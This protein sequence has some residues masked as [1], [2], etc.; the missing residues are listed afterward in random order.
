M[1]VS[2]KTTSKIRD[3]IRN[4]DPDHI[5]KHRKI[6]ED[7][8]YK[9]LKVNEGEDK[10]VYRDT[11]KDENI[12]VGI[13]FN[14]DRPSARAEWNGVFGFNEKG[15]ENISFDDVYQGKR[16]LTDGEIRRLF[17]YSISIREKRLRRGVYREIW[18]R[19][20][21]NERL[22]IEDIF[23]NGE[24]TIRGPGRTR[25]G[26]P[27]GA[28]NFYSHIKRYAETG[29]VRALK[30]AVYEVEHRSNKNGDLKS[31]RDT[32]GEMLAS[33]RI[34]Y[35]LMPPT[36]FA[37]VGKTVVP[38][39]PYELQFSLYLAHGDKITVSPWKPRDSNYYIWITSNDGHVRESHQANHRKVFRKDTPPSTGHPG[40]AF[41]C[42][43]QAIP[44]PEHLKVIEG[45]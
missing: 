8:R 19:L 45:I 15:E 17:D 10:K 39:D 28:T 22:A 7:E 32:E 6:Y 2:V 5:P 36:I 24:K 4:L 23:Y 18:P 31:R 30:R 12:T 38:R 3:R 20:G 41:G 35:E 43:C 14:M 34:K 27:I 16:E 26:K 11:S 9:Y 25:S 21:P 1:A 44:I 13:G 37:L 29:D 33:Y 40:E 42:R